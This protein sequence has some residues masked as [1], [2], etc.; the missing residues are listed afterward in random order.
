MDRS[1]F[2]KSERKRVAT[3]WTLNAVLVMFFVFN[4]T[5]LW[6]HFSSGNLSRCV[7]CPY[8]TTGMEVVWMCFPLL[9]TYVTWPN[10]N[11]KSRELFYR[12]LKWPLLSLVALTL[13]KINLR[14][15]NPNA[16][17]YWTNGILLECNWLYVSFA[18]LSIWISQN[19][20]KE[21]KKVKRGWSLAQRHCIICYAT[22]AMLML[23]T[24]ITYRLAELLSEDKS[25]Q[26][27]TASICEATF[28]LSPIKAS[29]SWHFRP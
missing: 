12:Y 10:M 2:L 20:R 3:F 24:V 21:S 27:L 29:L 7:V 8:A 16:A 13:A 25:T 22:P 17:Y 19:W 11:A 28:V 26:M 15:N 23:I 9:G 1:R 14:F 6:S 5:A 4:Q 18:N